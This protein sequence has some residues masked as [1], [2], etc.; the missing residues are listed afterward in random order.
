[1]SSLTENPIV[2]IPYPTNS[3]VVL[4][5]KWQLDTIEEFTIT[6]HQGRNYTYAE[7]DILL[8]DLLTDLYNYVKPSDN[9]MTFMHGAGNTSGYNGTWYTYSD[10]IYDGPRPS[11]SEERRVG[12]EC[13]SRWWPYHEKKNKK[14]K[15]YERRLKDKK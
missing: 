13:R 4:Y 14:E 12:K 5:A 7:R 15:Q 2:K 11:R 6:L 9:L 1:N 3:N 10:K 8:T